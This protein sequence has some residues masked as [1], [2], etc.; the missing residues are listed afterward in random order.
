[1]SKRADGTAWR[2]GKS[3]TFLRR[4]HFVLTPGQVAHA[5]FRYDRYLLVG[6]LVPSPAPRSTRSR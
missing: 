3:T 5:R 4:R 6:F 1:M 2:L